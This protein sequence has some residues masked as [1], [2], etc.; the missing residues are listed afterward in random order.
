[1]KKNKHLHLITAGIC[2]AMLTFV[3]AS[4]SL[5]GGD[6][7]SDEAEEAPV[8]HRVFI[9][10]IHPYDTVYICTGSGSKRFHASDTCSGLNGCRKEIRGLTRQEAEKKKRTHCQICISDEQVK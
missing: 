8:V 7:A 3:T 9:D 4:C 1:M 2:F 5:F 6:G 10:S